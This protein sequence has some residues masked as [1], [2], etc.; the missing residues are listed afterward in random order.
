MKKFAAYVFAI[1]LS[2]ISAM[3]LLTGCGGN[4]AKDNSSPLQSSEDDGGN[5]PSDDNGGDWTPVIPPRT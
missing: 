1:V 3:F 2:L 4:T 5:L